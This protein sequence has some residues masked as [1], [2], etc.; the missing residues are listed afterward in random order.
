MANEAA[1]GQLPKESFNIVLPDRVPVSVADWKSLANGLLTEEACAFHRNVEISSRYAWIY[2][3]LPSCFKWAA[4]AAIASNHVRLALLPLRLDADPS[5]YVNLPR[6]LNRHKV[7]L[8][9][10]VNAVRTTNNAIFDDI[11]WVHLAY[12]AGEDG[13]DVLRT[14]LLGDA[15]YSQVLVAFD[16]I[17]RG[18]RVLEDPMSLEHERAAATDAI[19]EGNVAILE[20]E[21]RALVQPNFDRLSGAFARIASMGSASTFEVRGLRQGLGYFTS[22][23]L[24]SLTRG[25]PRAARARTWPNI[26]RFEDRWPWLTTSVVPRFRRLDANQFMIQSSMRRILDEANRFGSTPCRPRPVP[27]AMNHTRLADRETALDP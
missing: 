13:M 6:S 22:F 18:R 11:F 7:L 4:M 24:S 20:H 15:H 25:L 19:W 9:E 26:I 21:Q 2:C 1:H 8:T 17:D 16:A 5:G 14:L 27:D 12:L 3:R 23:Y 10:D